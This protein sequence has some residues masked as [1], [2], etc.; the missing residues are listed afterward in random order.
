MIN[1]LMRADKINYELFLDFKKLCMVFNRNLPQIQCPFKILTGFETHICSPR[2]NQELLFFT[3]I[4]PQIITESTDVP[5]LDCGHIVY[6]STPKNPFINWTLSTTLHPLHH[7]GPI[8]H[9]P[10][11]SVLYSELALIPLVHTDPLVFV[12]LQIPHP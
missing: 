11:Q 12:H 7:G 9:S 10:L 2:S 8:P 3:T 4:D 5:I 6:R 1:N